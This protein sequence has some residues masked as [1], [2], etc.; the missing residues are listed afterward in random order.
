MSHIWIFHKIKYIHV[1]IYVYV[2]IIYIGLRKNHTY[3]R[4][5]HHRSTQKSHRVTLTAS[6]REK[7]NNI[8]CS[9]TK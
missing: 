4:A 6:E 3:H 9:L 5:P 7:N 1:C 8:F 2:Y